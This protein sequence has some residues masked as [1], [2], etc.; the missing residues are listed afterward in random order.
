MKAG[1]KL[2]SEREFSEILGVGRP[3]VREAL[4]I[5]DAF[6]IVDIRQYDG[7]YVAGI[8]A[9]RLSIP[10]KVRMGMGQFDLSQLFEMRR[11]FEVEIMKLAA[12]HITPE[13]LD[14]LGSILE[15]ENIDDAEQFAESD[16]EFHATIYRSTGNEFLVIIMQIVNELSSLSRRITGRFIDTRRIVHADHLSILDALKSKNAD[17]CE[18]AM[19]QHID[20]IQ[21]I[22]ELDTKVYESVFQQQLKALTKTSF[23]EKNADK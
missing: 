10:F 16:S 18:R 11:I 2:P 12:C 5:A 6:G 1:D 14:Y 21:K 19:L 15:K 22:I 23:N 7:I 8:E 4:K 20:H 3:T 13:Q 9:E 17:D